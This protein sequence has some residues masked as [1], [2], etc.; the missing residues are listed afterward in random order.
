MNDNWFE[1]WFNSRY[2]HLLYNNRNDNEAQF[3][4]D[5]LIKYL[6]TKPGEKFL[7]VA[8]GK[9]R[10]SKYLA[11]KKM[12]V[13]GIDLAS[14]SIAEAKKME[15]DNL[16][17]YEHDMRRIFRA[18]Y[19]DVVG[20]FFTSMGYFEKPHDDEK[21][22][23]ALQTAL[24]KG[25]SLVIDFMNAKKVIHNLVANEKLEKE[26][27]VFEINRYVEN[28]FI[29]KNTKVF[30][31][32]VQQIVANEK[33]KAFD[34][35]QFEKLLAHQNLT[36]KNVFGNYALDNFDEQNSDRLIIHAIKN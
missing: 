18:N 28:G 5:N 27:C 8:C 30:E 12:D 11:T 29:C 19:F 24:K 33:V 2:Y 1:T 9:G 26:N 22:F 35:A 36:I 7:D 31:N 15:T 14:Q 3:F 21:Q 4:I 20:S 23:N 13:C 6:E 32:D 17:F 34:L 10:H 25:G 16:H